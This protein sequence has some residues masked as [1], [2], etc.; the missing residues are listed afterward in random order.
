MAVTE[1]DQV[2]EGTDAVILLMP[3][4]IALKLHEQLVA[5]G[6]DFKPD[7]ILEDHYDP[8]T[9]AVVGS[10]GT[11]LGFALVPTDREELFRSDELIQ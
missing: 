6:F 8:G 10:R 9:N 3:G 2:N 11:L 4:F 5:Q 1:I 7:R